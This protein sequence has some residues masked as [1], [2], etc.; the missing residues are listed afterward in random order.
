M[1]KLHLVG[2]TAGLDGLIFSV[3]KGSTSGGFTVDLDDALVQMVTDAERVRTGGMVV[4][5]AGELRQPRHSWHG[6]ALNPRELQDRLRSGWSV[7][8]VA[9]EAGTDVAWVKR[10]A[11]P[12]LAEQAQVVNRARA[13]T[14]DK[15]RL[16]PS[17]LNLGASVR[18][19]L[20]E[21]G[22]RMPDDD[23][24]DGWSAFQL[25][26]G[27]WVIRFDFT[28][29]GRAQRA[30]WL[31]DLADGH[32]SARDR[33]A[34]QLGHVGGGGGK[35]R[36]RSTA[37][38]P[39]VLLEAS[40]AHPSPS[41]GAGGPAARASAPPSK[42]ATRV[43]RATA[44]KSPA[45]KSPAKKSPAKKVTPAK[46]PAKKVAPKKVAPK[47]V[48]PAKKA[49]KKLAPA[50]KVAPKK[51]APAKKGAPKKVSATRTLP[52]K[53]VAA[54]EAVEATTRREIP[55][56]DPAKT[57]SPT[58]P[59]DQ[60]S[61]PEPDASTVVALP[62]QPPMPSPGDGES[63]DASAEWALTARQTR[64][65][66]GQERIF[67]TAPTARTARPTDPVPPS[68]ST[69]RRTEDRRETEDRDG[70]AESA[71]RGERSVV[72]GPLPAPAP[73]PVPERVREAVVEPIGSPPVTRPEPA[74]PTGA[75]QPAPADPPGPRPKPSLPRSIDGRTG[76]PRPGDQ[77]RA[78]PVF[79]PDLIRSAGN[80]RSARASGPQAAPPDDDLQ[81]AASSSAWDEE[82]PGEPSAMEALASL[83]PPPD[84]AESP[85][86][87][88]GRRRRLRRG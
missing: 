76:A 73:L 40:S 27:L 13:F 53:K 55:R 80:G 17:T 64:S 43:K 29:R 75:D 61:R 10:F 63:D 52:T 8:E 11:A 49:P 83:Y 84:E 56:V 62:P 9:E 57:A 46:A 74:V 31:L 25:D 7:E 50:K 34:S 67:R 32:L 71:D 59:S 69:D 66:S 48:A 81:A 24:E 86:S 54:T 36:G 21:R 72:H 85:P 65:S 38:A 47:K 23:A 35:A 51:V 19:N 15:A 20:A 16:G 1:Q 58:A 41:V 18:R 2:F 68:P 77:G 14:F 37:V 30:E 78:G 6:S 42:K 28:S 60:E 82:G 33:L 87:A 5:V 70:P 39:E 22:R 44:K 26:D 3:R 12:V 79:R 88:K 4:Q 45:K